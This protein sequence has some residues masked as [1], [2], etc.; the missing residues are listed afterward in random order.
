MGDLYIPKYALI[1]M[2][3]PSTKNSLR[4]VEAGGETAVLL[5]LADCSTAACGSSPDT[6]LQAPTLLKADEFAN[7]ARLLSWMYCTRHCA[8]PLS[9]WARSS[10]V[11]EISGCTVLQCT[12][13]ICNGLPWSHGP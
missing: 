6:L 11:S 9:I 4:L 7:S 13:L 2:L 3:L 12:V 1:A 8:R 10:A 5:L